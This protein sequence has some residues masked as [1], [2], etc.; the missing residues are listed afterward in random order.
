[1]VVTAVHL[2]VK[3]PKRSQY[4]HAK[5]RKYRTRNWTDYNKAL[6]RRGDLTIWF[7]EE[8]IA[9]WKSAKTGKAGGQQLYSDVAIETGLVVRM[10]YKLGYRQTQ[11]FLNSITLL[12]GLSI[13][14]PHYST[15]CRRSTT[16]RKKLRVPKGTGN[17]P[18]HLM[19]DS[20]GLKIH[21]GSSRK[22][23]KKRAWRKLHIAVDR[24]TGIVVASELTASQA[25]DASRVPALLKQIESPLASVSADKAYDEEPV[26]EEIAAHSSGRRTRVI[27]PP[28]CNA[29]LSPNSKT[30]MQDR[31][32]HIRAIE[33]YGRRK[34]H[35]RSGYT[36]RSM[37]ENTIYRYKQIIGPEMRART[38]A[39]QR[40]E[41]RI[42]CE[43]LNKMTALG[44]PDTYCAG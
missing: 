25:R 39:R 27:I 19:I 23:P 37:V 11:G 33:K 24:K 10:I 32:R 20:S 13:E 2:I 40:V 38:L 6:C 8:A 18:I 15:L 14:I 36:K 34:W 44:M 22:P 29:T 26:Y 4:K 43:I 5:N 12:L 17:Q 9:K 41:H 1:M 42:G 28:R 35:K 31:N 3:Y 21:V 16:L 7:S 30:A